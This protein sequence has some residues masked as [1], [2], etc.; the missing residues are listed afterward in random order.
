LLPPERGATTFVLRPAA[1]DL[2][3]QGFSTKRISHFPFPEDDRTLCV[4]FFFFRS[5]GIVSHYFPGFDAVLFGVPAIPSLRSNVTRGRCQLGPDVS[6]D[7]NLLA[8]FNPPPF[9][10]V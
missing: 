4:S 9:L 7:T 6:E 1:P 3:P 2:P 10:L 5:A 8:L